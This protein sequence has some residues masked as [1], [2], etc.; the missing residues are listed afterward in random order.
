MSQ[1][2]HDTT[3]HLLIIV[4]RRIGTPIEPSVDP[5]TTQSEERNATKEPAS[6]GASE[7]RSNVTSFDIAVR[8]PSVVT[9]QGQRIRESNLLAFALSYS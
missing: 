6:N 1:Q 5:K 9:E 3:L 4:L 2:I 8:T 7:T